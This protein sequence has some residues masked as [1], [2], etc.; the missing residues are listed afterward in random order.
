MNSS[1]KILFHACM[2]SMGIDRRGPTLK[3]KWQNTLAVIEK[4]NIYT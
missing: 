2:G 1:S 3:V 4:S